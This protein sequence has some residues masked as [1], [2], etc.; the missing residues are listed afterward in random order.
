MC[1]MMRKSS[2]KSALVK[3]CFAMVV[4]GA[5]SIGATSC[6]DE[7]DE[8]VE[9]DNSAPAQ[10]TNVQ[11][12]AGPG[13]VYLTWNIPQSSS[14]MYTKI[15]YLD[16]KG[17]MQYQIISKERADANGRCNATVSGFVST[18][19][20]KFSLYACAVKGNNV[21]AVELEAS[22]GAPAFTA[23]AESV[24]V[25][26][27]EGG[28]LVNYS[29][30]FSVSAFIQIDYQAAGDASKAGSKSFEVAANSTGSQWVQLSY[31]N[32]FIA[33]E[34]CTIS[35]RG[36]D[37]AGNMSEAREMTVTP[38]PVVKVDRTAWAFPGYDDKSDSET[39]GYS[40]QETKGEGGG[41]SP[42]GRVIAMIDGDVNTFWHATWKSQGTKYPHWFILDMGKNVKV[43]SIELLRRQGKDGAKC[44]TGQQ[45]Y[46]CSEENAT[47]PTAPD[48]WAWD[49]RG[50]YAFDANSETPQAYRMTGT[51]SVRY[52]KVYFGEQYK[53]TGDQAMLAEINVYTVE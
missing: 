40:S 13:E 34:A 49:D 18:D 27:D 26:P 7:A 16:A 3:G 1:N 30:E 19:P 47:N 51:P 22:P 28:I 14:F 52:I 11:T 17:E 21:G 41:K 9:I 35:V 5:L 48:T 6:L 38:I 32:E 4:L 33:G 39:I 44:Q 20:V 45:F 31:G 23:V 36:K 10:V 12:S 53:G 46:L 25:E 50:A 29:N 43:S 24:T 2:W 37:V 15:E 42:A 8:R